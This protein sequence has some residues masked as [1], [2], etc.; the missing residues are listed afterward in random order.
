MGGSVNIAVLGKQS[1][2]EGFGRRGT[3]TDLA[4]FDKR[5]AGV[6]RTWVA[7]AGF[8]DKVQPLLQALGM[9]EHVVFC[10]DSLDRFAGEQVIALDLLGKASGILAHTDG[11]DGD[12]LES[13]VGGTAVEGYARAGPDGI[14]AAMAGFEPAGR[15]GRPL[16]EIDHC[17]DVKGVGTVALGRVSRGTVKKYDRMVLQPA[18]AE[19]L[20]KSI[21]MHDEPVGEAPSPARVGLALK[22]VG[23]DDVGRGDVLAAG[24]A[25]V[26]TEVRLGFEQ[27]PFYRGEVAPGQGCLVSVGLQV[28]AARVSAGGPSLLELE[29]PV[30]CERG[31]TAVLLRPESEST[32]VIGGG[33]VL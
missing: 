21:Q 17:F 15:D 33:P 13:M 20:V 3:V 7:P 31:Q 8:P 11:V 6:V 18:G 19:V 16:V 14:A 22:G 24:D 30:F 26:R 23:P 5:Q 2:A 27:S 9:S 12:V 28:R 32:R 1:I 29:R 10:V 4:M 25:D